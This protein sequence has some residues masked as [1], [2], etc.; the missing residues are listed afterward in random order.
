MYHT[1]YNRLI[2]IYEIII[3]SSHITF[4]SNTYAILLYRSWEELKIFSTSRS[5]LIWVQ[6]MTLIP[7]TI[8]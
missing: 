5:H 3:I 2:I 8:Y 6:K 7:I 1:M 4:L